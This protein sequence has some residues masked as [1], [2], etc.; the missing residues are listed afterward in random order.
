[1]TMSLLGQNLLQMSDIIYLFD[2]PKEKIT[3]KS[4]TFNTLYT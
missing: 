4:S 1:M 2:K 3:I